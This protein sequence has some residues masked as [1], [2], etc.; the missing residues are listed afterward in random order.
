MRIDLARLKRDT[1]S[2][3]S[4]STSADVPDSARPPALTITPAPS[5]GRATV[6]TS[7]AASAT[8]VKRWTLVLAAALLVVGAAT[9]AFFLLRSP[10][11]PVLTA[12]DTIVLTDFTNTTGDAVFDGTLTQALA[13]HLG[14]SPFLSI[15][16]AQRVR[17]TLTLMGRQPDDRVTRAL[18]QEVCQRE[19]A[20][21]M[22]AGTIAGIGSRYAITLDAVNCQTGASLAAEQVE[23]ASKDAVLE[24]LGM[25]ASRLRGKLGESLATIEKLD[26]PI[27]RATTSSLE[28]LK[29]YSLGE[30]ER[31][32]GRATSSI[33]LYKRAIELDPNF[34]LAHGRLGTVYSN[35]GETD[36]GRQH[37]SKAFE[38]RDR[39]SEYERLYITAHYHAA[40][41]GEIEKAEETYE[42]WKKT[43]PRDWTPQ[44]N[45]A[46][47][48]LAR[49]Q[50]ERAL[51]EA[52]EALRKQPDHPLPY[53]NVAWS[54]IFLG[55]LDEGRAVFQQAIDRKFDTSDAHH[56]LI[57]IGY[58]QGDT[59]ALAR[60]AKWAEGA[61]SGHAVVAAQGWFAF[62][63]G[64][65]RE[66]E[67]LFRAA[68][69]QSRLQG[70]R[71]Q[72]AQYLV[73]QASTE[74]S[75]GRPDAARRSLAAATAIFPPDEPDPVAAFVAASAGDEATA[76][77]HANDLAAR[78]P[79]DTLLRLQML[80]EINAALALARNQP[81]RAIEL[82]EPARPFE[83]NPR[84]P[85]I[86]LRGRAYLRANRP[87]DA[88]AELEKVLQRP[89]FLPLSGF[90]SVYRLEFARAAAAAGDMAASRK[91][92]QDLIA[93]LKDA[94]PD[95]PLLI[96]ARAEYAKLGG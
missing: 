15:V 23:A 53:A 22:L 46:V 84:S 68:S 33:A 79:S 94:D 20:R 87:T 27:E 54:Y 88:R 14:Q 29:A 65:Q 89:A 86:F 26:T 52:A 19:G 69:E 44:N 38:L 71:Q 59:E 37:R 61:S 63:A 50:H 45:L 55:R 2:G 56:A 3:R 91:A 64:R 16:P 11:S 18:G 12:R 30:A 80:P 73:L 7:G 85:T 96:H 74:A 1:D 40:V 42:L 43:Y 5:P 57:W 78:H 95:F 81:A 25:A 6:S 66:A 67:R 35:A 13:V 83:L 24:S 34:A 58:L 75:I 49:G 60:E 17:E 90:A 31:A 32:S 21:A 72:A 76:E 92:Y 51:E 9:A 10:A 82:L 41:T 4:V 8:T 62:M 48:H 39:V 36:L 28:A 93:I 70:Y 77:R 47:L